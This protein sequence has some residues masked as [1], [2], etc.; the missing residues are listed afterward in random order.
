MAVR[1]QLLAVLVLP[2]AAM[3]TSGAWRAG[4]AYFLPIMLQLRV[5]TTVGAKPLATCWIATR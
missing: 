5:A 3:A 4:L 1:S 2:W